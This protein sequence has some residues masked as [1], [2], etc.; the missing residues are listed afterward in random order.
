MMAADIKFKSDPISLVLGKL[1]QVKP[2]SNSQWMA[3]CPAHDDRT[4]SL[5]I[6]RGEDGCVLLR[7][8]AG[9]T[10]QII[11]DVIGL[12]MTDLF[13]KTR[14]GTNAHDGHGR[15]R[16]AKKSN[17]RPF[18][19]AEAAI[20]A[21]QGSRKLR[22]VT[23]KQHVYDHDDIVLRF[24]FTDE[25][26][27]EI[28]PIS[29]IDAGWVQKAKKGQRK[30]YRVDEL[31]E[32]G[33]VVFAEGEECADA[34]WSI[35]IPATCSPG[36]SA[37]RKNPEANCDFEPLRGRRVAIFA[38]ND[39]PGRGLAE[40]VARIV[41]TK[42]GNPSLPILPELSKGGD[43]VDFVEGHDSRDN[44]DIRHMVLAIID[45]A[46]DWQPG[47]EDDES[48]LQWVPFPVHVLPLALQDFVSKGAKAIG[49]NPSMIALPMLAALAG[50]IGTTRRIRLKN[51]WKEPVPL[52][53]VVIAESGTLKSPAQDYALRPLFDLQSER[54][55]DHDEAMKLYTAEHA[56]YEKAKAAFRHDKSG[57]KPPK[58][59]REPQCV[60]LVVSATTV[61]ALAPILE[62]NARGVLMARDELAGWMGGFNQYKGG[63]GGDAAQWLEMQRAGALF[64]DRKTG[65]RR[66]IHVAHAAVSVAGTIQPGVL[67]RLLGHENFENGLAA[68]ILMVSP[69]R[70]ETLWRDDDV[71]DETVKKFTDLLETLFGLEHN[72]DMHDRPIAVDVPLSKAA[73]ECWEA[74]YNAH[75]A[76]MAETQGNL[77]AA[78]SK[79]QGY[80]ARFAL[81]FHLVK[82]ATVPDYGHDEI[83]ADTVESAV[84]LAR[85]FCHE[86]ERT[87][88]MLSESDEDRVQRELIEYIAARGGSITV[89]ELSRGPQRYRSGDAA[90]R[91]LQ[92]LVDSAKAEWDHSSGG[93]AGQPARRVRLLCSSVGDGS[94]GDS[95]SPCGH[96]K[97]DTVTV[98]SAATSKR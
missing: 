35:G 28:R 98:A 73:L 9:C 65:D 40:A 13:P 74:F 95:I 55:H 71:S 14:N 97:R 64:I 24:R 37:T 51:S 90:Q 67:R 78:F 86:T 79:I 49:C 68:R 17:P 39:E 81:V 82:L 26:S 83:Q 22:G 70:T 43:I 2:V 80:A 85:W 58:E 61:E 6:G 30:L 63:K 42:S 21:Y 12:K 56:E 69:P 19:T 16:R 8:H 15:A 47:Q 20:A 54:F 77:A 88:G 62:E 27:K 5:S 33:L 48:P 31:P 59:P 36:G 1:S 60:R 66:R 44:D 3:L 7:C 84:E 94:D 92:G 32:T 93:K 46:P 75:A 10:P 11:A 18:P 72:Y 76:V 57:G 87:Y 91:A 23:V 89:R 96:G 4:P 41:H 45:E 34:F 25:R 53:C 50:V 52:W 29:K 38:D